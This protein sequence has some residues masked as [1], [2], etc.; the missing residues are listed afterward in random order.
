MLR[1]FRYTYRGSCIGA[2]KRIKGQFEEIAKRDDTKEKQ[3]KIE[4]ICKTMTQQFCCD[5]FE[6]FISIIINTRRQKAVPHFSLLII[7]EQTLF[8]LQNRN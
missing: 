2:G 7:I 6:C 3:I 8:L 5:G 1:K 4:I